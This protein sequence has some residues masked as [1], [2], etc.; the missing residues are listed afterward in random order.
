M[1]R[2]GLSQRLVK[3]KEYDEIRE[4]LDIRWQ[5]LLMS[6]NM[7]PVN[8]PSK[9]GYSFFPQLKLDGI[10]LT[11]GNDLYSQSKNDLSKMR[12]TLEYELIKYS[13]K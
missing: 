10:I 4:T 5:T 7:L 1:K 6:L 9:L 12:D 13:M 2:I 11:G 8:I 3:H